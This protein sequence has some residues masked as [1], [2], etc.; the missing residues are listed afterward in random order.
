MRVLILTRRLLA[1]ACVLPLASPLIRVEARRSAGPA[2]GLRAIAFKQTPPNFAFR[3]PAGT[4][5]LHDY[6]GAPVVVNF[7]ATWCQPC[8]A[9]L[10]AFARLHAA[11]G[12]RV[13]LL[14]ISSEAPGVASAYLAAHAIDAIAVEDDGHRIADLYSVTAIPVTLVLGRDGR[15]AHVSVGQIDWPELHAAVEPLVA[16]PAAAVDL[17]PHAKSGTLGGNAGTPSP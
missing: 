7:W 4:G 5:Q 1:V 2:T 10:E 16:A 13:P 8:A 9:E 11:F 14:A 12:A 17:T 3:T 6:I 15:V